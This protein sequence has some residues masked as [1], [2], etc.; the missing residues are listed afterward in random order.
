MALHETGPVSYISQLDDASDDNVK[1]ACGA[2][3]VDICRTLGAKL[4][5]CNPPMWVADNVACAHE[6]SKRVRQ[7]LELGGDAAFELIRNDGAY[8]PQS[9]IYFD[10]VPSE[11]SALLGHIASTHISPKFNVKM[12]GKQTMREALDRLHVDRSQKDRLPMHMTAIVF[13]DWV[14]GTHFPFATS[15]NATSSI[16]GVETPATRQIDANSTRDDD[17]SGWAVNDAIEG[18]GIVVRSRPGRLLLFASSF[19]STDVPLYASLHQGIDDPAIGKCRLMSVVGWNG[20]EWETSG[21]H[22]CLEHETIEMRA[23]YFE[24]TVEEE[25]LGMAATRSYRTGEANAYLERLARQRSITI[26]R[27]I[28]EAAGKDTNGTSTIV[29]DVARKLRAGVA[30]NSILS[31]HHTDAIP[32]AAELSQAPAIIYTSDG[33]CPVCFGGFSDAPDSAGALDCGHMIC[34]TCYDEMKRHTQLLR[35]NRVC[36]PSCRAASARWTGCK[37]VENKWTAITEHP[38]AEASST[39]RYYATDVRNWLPANYSG[40]PDPGSGC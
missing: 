8:V 6:F 39:E 38:P 32:S 4:I 40:N 22:E 25:S 30:L 27:L 7:H 10:D 16:D 11:L 14:G 24:R 1:K 12:Y 35:N 9:K 13:H 5:S 2:S 17:V 23:H 29:Q 34:K 19:A 36:C 21:R 37:Q 18:G 31:R 3:F 15:T 33:N 20:R 26:E 28:R